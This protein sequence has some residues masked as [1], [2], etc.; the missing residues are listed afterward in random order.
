MEPRVIDLSHPD[1]LKNRG[2]RV[3][4]DLNDLS[5]YTYTNKSGQTIYGLRCDK[6]KVESIVNDKERLFNMLVSY[7]KENN[8]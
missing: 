3:V 8:G 2:L 7:I 1:P 4:I 5:D 6:Y